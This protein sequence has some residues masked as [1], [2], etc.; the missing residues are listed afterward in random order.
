MQERQVARKIDIK[1]INRGNFVQ[2]E[3]KSEEDRYLP[4]YIEV[5]GMKISR[6]RVLATVIDKFV[7]EDGNY[8]TLTL[9]DTTD[10]I[11]C[12]IFM[13]SNFSDNLSRQNLIDLE[14]IN[15]IEKGDLIDV[16]GKIKEYNEERY[17]QPEII[18]KIEDPN[19]EVLRKLEIEKY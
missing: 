1:T 13:N 19:F 8:A 2:I 4:N 7:S 10:T 12:K 17:I 15:N 16:I 14:T 18:V 5:N 3:R 11:R 9:D 6:V